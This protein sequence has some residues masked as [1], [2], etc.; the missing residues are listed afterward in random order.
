MKNIGKHAAKLAFLA[1]LVV[2]GIGIG[3]AF[4]GKSTV[5]AQE[6]EPVAQQTIT[7]SGTGEKSIRP[8]IAYVDVGVR[9][10]SD[11][12]KTAQE[13][14]TR[15]M[16]A[17][18]E[19]I[20][21]KNI[22]EKDIQTASFFVNPLYDQDTWTR[23]TG[24]EVIHSVRV[25]VSEIDRAGEVIDAAIQAG[26]NHSNGISFDISREERDRLYSEALKEAVAQG[27]TKANVL[28]ESI[29]KSLGEPL[30]I[31]EGGV[32]V[33]PYM[34][35]MMVSREEADGAGTS[36]QPGEMRVQASVT[37]VYPTK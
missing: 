7:V 20:K 5:Q 9:T 36:L 8:S 23:V 14:N 3:I 33:E 31:A 22:D 10:Q 1:L 2:I 17:V 16:H 34:G 30:R 27:E 6:G 24:F 28:A 21:G 29:G 4:Q 11:V 37:L 18:L 19:A 32:P 12:M 13:E 26:A 25:K 15:Q 35:D